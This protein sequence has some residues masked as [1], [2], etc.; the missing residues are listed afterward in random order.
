MVTPDPPPPGPTV[1]AGAPDPIDALGLPSYR[2]DMVNSLAGSAER[3]VPDPGR[4]IRAYANAGAAMNLVRALTSGGMAD[5]HEVQR[6]RNAANGHETG[7]RISRSAR[8][9]RAERPAR[10]GR[11]KEVKS[12][13]GGSD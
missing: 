10:Q 11:A 4:M 6:Q 12:S 3:R 8:D 5:L 9:A 1:P 13:T 2:G 7:Q